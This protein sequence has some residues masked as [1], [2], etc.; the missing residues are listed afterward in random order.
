MKILL[1]IILI[2]AFNLAVI[3]RELNTPWLIT[4]INGLGRKQIQEIGGAD[5]NEAF[6]NFRKNNPNAE[7]LKLIKFSEIK[8]KE[9]FK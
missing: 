3:P 7:I 5:F 9:D 8:C 2:L 6:F 4:F 1:T